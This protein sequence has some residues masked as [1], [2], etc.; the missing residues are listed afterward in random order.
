MRLCLVYNLQ[1]TIVYILSEK[2]QI[3][4][5]G[6]LYINKYDTYAGILNYDT[7]DKTSWTHYT[8]IYILT[9]NFTVYIR[10]V[11]PWIPSIAKQRWHC[12]FDIYISFQ[13]RFQSLSIINQCTFH[14][15]NHAREELRQIVFLARVTGYIV[16][17]N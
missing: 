5:Q 12:V 10:T 3:Y 4:V 17:T 11:Q 16:K 14:S 9:W 1:D 8:N 7:N 2:K 13:L 6:L 15:S